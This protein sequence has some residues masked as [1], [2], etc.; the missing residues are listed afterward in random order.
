MEPVQSNAI[1]EDACEIPVFK[2]ALVKYLGK[3]SVSRRADGV[4]S[5]LRCLVCLVLTNR[6][7]AEVVGL[8]LRFLWSRCKSLGGKAFVICS[9]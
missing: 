5:E 4:V 6:D 1:W 2:H 9:W 7:L 8:R 3:G